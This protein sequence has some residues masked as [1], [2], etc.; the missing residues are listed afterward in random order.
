MRLLPT[1]TTTEQVK[2]MPRDAATYEAAVAHLC[3]VHGLPS[4][5]P[6]T[7]YA[8]GNS[9]VF[10]IGTEHVLKL[11][12]PPDVELA[13]TEAQVLAHVHGRLGMPTPA[14]YATGELEGWPYVLMGQLPGL[15]LKEAWPRIPGLRRLQLLQSLGAALRRLHALP[16]LPL[17]I[18][19][20]SWERFLVQ[21]REGCVARQR[22]RGVPEA[23]LEQMPAFLDAVLA[24]LEP[25]PPPV[26]LHT[27]VMRDHLL[28]EEREGAWELTGLIDF[29]P[30]M[31][32]HPDYELAS[33][34]VFVSG[35][36]GAL[37]R[38]V[39][40]GYGREG[41]GLSRE[42]RQRALAFTLL[43]RYSN[44]R[45]YLDTVP[46]AAEVHTL[47]ALADAWWGTETR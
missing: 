29:E 24:Q 42:V 31:C 11:M 9:I 10:A 14:L 3:D 33:V 30:A 35:G 17:P 12:A 27:E 36:D 38:A 39:C 19:G 47:E 5:A 6:R 44:L 43:H 15:S 32:G 28:V 21:Q 16:T 13:R 2:H 4:Q 34:G 18:P 46:T 20:D 22:A 1:V 25:Q 23:W 45:W 41:G 40:A 8:T 37:L 26:L 7:K